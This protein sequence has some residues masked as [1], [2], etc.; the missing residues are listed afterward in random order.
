MKWEFL[1]ELDD[2]IG[3]NGNG[4]IRKR[5]FNTLKKLIALRKSHPAFA[6]VDME[7][8]PLTNPHV[9]GFNPRT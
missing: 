5:I 8:I 9:L 6:G 1:E 3:T 4:S 2:H 7:L